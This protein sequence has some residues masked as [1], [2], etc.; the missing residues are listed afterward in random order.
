MR[1][2]VRYIISRKDYAASSWEPA[3]TARTRVHICDLLMRDVCMEENFLEYANE[4][5]WMDLKIRQYGKFFFALGVDP[6]VMVRGY[7]LHN[8]TAFFSRGSCAPSFI[9]L[10]YT[11][12]M[13]EYPLRKYFKK[14]CGRY[15]RVHCNPLLFHGKEPSSPDLMDTD[16]TVINMM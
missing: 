9:E 5:P 2:L 14:L 16:L 11:G 12:R 15:M 10:I 8:Y 7:T 6:L 4:I 3:W 13:K 1:R